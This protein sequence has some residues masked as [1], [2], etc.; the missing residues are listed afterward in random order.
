M[1]GKITKLT[2]L[3]IFLFKKKH[4]HLFSQIRNSRVSF[5]VNIVSGVQIL[6]TSACFVKCIGFG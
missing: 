5:A 2:L 6:T 4:K 3:E 1:L